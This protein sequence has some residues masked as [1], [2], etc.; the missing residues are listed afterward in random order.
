MTA[1]TKTCRTVALIAG[2]SLLS[3]LSVASANPENPEPRGPD[4]QEIMPPPPGFPPPPLRLPPPIPALYQASLQAT[5]PVLAA[6]KLVANV[7]Q[8]GGKTYE[9]SISVREVPPEP[10]QSTATR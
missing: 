4:R 7:P 3:A 5:D 6:N 1:L 10:P 8:G 9:V 2:I